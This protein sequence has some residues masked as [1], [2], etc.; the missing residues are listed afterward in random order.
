MK[1][2]RWLSSLPLRVRTLFKKRAAEK[3]LE[4]E[5][6]FHVER[7]VEALVEQGFS[8]EAARAMAMKQMG[9][10]ERQMEQCRDVRAWQGLEVLRADVRFGYRQLMKRKVTTAAA[11]LSL[12]LGIGSCVAAF[13]LVDALF[14]RPM[15]VSDPASLYVATY[16]RQ[17]TEYL[18]GFFDTNPYPLF[19]HAR[20]ATKGEAEVAAASTMNHIDLTYGSDA[21]TEKAYRQWVSGEMFS[22]LGL[23]PA[24]GRLLTEDDD[25]VIGKSP[26]AVISYDYWQRRF[27]RDPKIVGRTFRMGDN[28]YEIVGVAPKGF[29]GTEPGTITD[30]F[31]PA[32]MDPYV[33]RSD[34]FHLRIFVRPKAGVNVTLLSDKMNA[35]YQQWENERLKTWPKDVVALIPKATLELKSA[36]TGASTMQSEYGSALTVLGALVGLVLLIAC[37]NVANLMAAQ[38]TA[39]AREMALRM[40]LGSG[41]ARLVR[42][43][44]VESAML[45]L[46]AAALGMAFAEWATP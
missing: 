19:E 5:I 27:G 7:Q 23:K 33:L 37:A 4:E 10:V 14:L 38:A 46:M 28:V 13:R 39:R 20:D 21:E 17:A 42:M 36:G 8:P 24:R 43:V 40:A 1:P 44:M 35:T 30:I 29:T 12:A 15:P 11:V 41:R 9:N 2:S 32:K 25:R 34:L 26:Y 6:R 18:P 22:M 3:E 31:A 45:A 16:T